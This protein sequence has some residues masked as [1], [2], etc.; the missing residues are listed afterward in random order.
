[1]KTSGSTGLHIYIPLGAKY[2]YKQARDFAHLVAI[3]TVELLPE[4]TTIER[5]LQKRDK[6]KLYV[7]YLQ[8][9]KGQTIAS[10]Y[11]V[12]P[13][14]GATASAPLEWKEVKPGLE[15]GQFDIHTLP[16]RVEKI[17]DLFKP[18]LGR[19]IN[20]EKIL[21]KMGR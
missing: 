10:P 2:D 15:I 5:S 19:G 14:P 12:R 7:D 17:G 9:K 1:M 20:L 13:K 16:A 3:K 18:V 4:I 8:N 6:G 21:E 11:S